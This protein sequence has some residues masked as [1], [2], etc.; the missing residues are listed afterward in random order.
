MKAYVEIVKCRLLKNSTI[1]RVIWSYFVNHCLVVD[2]IILI[3]QRLIYCLE[4]I[5]RK[6]NRDDTVRTVYRIAGDV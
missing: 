2:E 6:L 1:K 5:E 3:G 4:I